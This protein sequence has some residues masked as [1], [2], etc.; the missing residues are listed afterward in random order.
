MRASLFCSLL[1]LASLF[2]PV[3]AAG[4][5]PTLQPFSAS[6]LWNTA[7]GSGA[8]WSG[9]ADPD[10]RDLRSAPIVINAGQ[11]SMPIYT[12]RP[13]D[14]LTY[15]HVTDNLFP[16]PDQYLRAPFDMKPAAPA[17]GDRHIILFDATRRWMWH[18]FGCRPT[19]GALARGF[20][21]GLAQQDDVCDLGYG[22]YGYGSGTIR[23]FELEAGVIRHML[24]FALGNKWEKSGP[25]WT[26]GVAWPATREDYNGPTAFKG[27]VLFG[28]TIGIPASV[29]ITR[30][31]LSR[32]GL[33]L[34]RALQDY[35]ALMRD[36]DEC[37]LLFYAEAAAEGMPE[38]EDMRRDAPRLAPYLAILRN[39]SQ[40]TP[41]G[42]GVRR[43]PPAEPIDPAICPVP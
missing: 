34:A 38:L 11:W 27:H 9:P 5:D 8:R 40:S 35:G 29:D 7:I 21:C 32:S 22:D 41:N 20:E 42:G 6:S 18:Y 14:P 19:R 24:R 10:T 33:A 43:Q 36:S 28:S 26:S 13:S 12:A 30:L 17:D 39:Q 2:R 31:G 16:V 23:T 15:F 1:L 4:R 3:E 37:C 25:A